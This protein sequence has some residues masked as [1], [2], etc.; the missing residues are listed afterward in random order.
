MK[1]KP[2]LPIVRLRECSSLRQVIEGSKAYHCEFYVNPDTSRRR[3]R[4][5]RRYLWMAMVMMH[6]TRARCGTPQ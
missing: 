3:A 1:R 4:M 2:D 5:S 6:A